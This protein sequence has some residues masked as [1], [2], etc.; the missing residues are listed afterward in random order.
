ML[1]FAVIGCGVIGKVHA[2][3]IGR[4]ERAEVA[5]TCDVIAERAE[6]V[7][8]QFGGKPVVGDMAWLERDDYDAVSIATPHYMHIDQFRAAVGAGKHVYCEKPLAI[9]PDDLYEMKRIAASANVV[10][11]GIFQHR[12]SRLYLAAFK[13]IMNGALGKITGAS[14]R[15]TLERTREY[16]AADEWRGKWATEGGGCCINQ[17]I[18]TLDLA[19]SFLG[20]PV[21][22]EAEARRRRMDTIEVEDWARGVVEFGA[23][24]TLDFEI[25]ND[26][27]GGWN[28]YYSIRGERGEFAVRGETV[29]TL[30]TDDREFVAAVAAAEHCAQS[31]K[32]SPGKKCYGAVHDIAFGDFI[33]AVLGERKPR[34]PIAEAVRANEIVLGIY[35][36]TAT[37]EKIKLPIGNYR[38][39]ELR[40][41]GTQTACGRS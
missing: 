22:V 39:P 21:A 29:E 18:H 8:H 32:D 17:A 24:A 1:R 9:A 27:D 40:L 3:A 4:D 20:D 25:S 11:A 26:P 7:A 2:W 16:Y 12:Y 31:E 13:H 30:V 34:V 15:M 28:P 19:A 41:G 37:G 38:R 5:Y 14:V 35:H 33:G 6:A 23:G 36:S 10:T